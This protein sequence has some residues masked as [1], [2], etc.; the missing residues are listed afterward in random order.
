MEKY[1]NMKGY[2]HTMGNAPIHSLTDI[3]KCIHSQGYQCIYIPSCSSEPS[4]I[5]HF[6]SVVRSKIKR[7]FFRKRNTNDWN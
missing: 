6:W 7:K 2:Y 3:E 4:P 5:E 1:V